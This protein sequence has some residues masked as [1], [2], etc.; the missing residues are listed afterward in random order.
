[1]A[2]HEFPP[3][4]LE[5]LSQGRVRPM[6]WENFAH[7]KSSHIRGAWHVKIYGRFMPSRLKVA[8]DPV[9]KQ[10]VGHCW[11][12][13]LVPLCPLH[14][15]VSQGSFSATLLSQTFLAKSGELSSA[16]GFVESQLCHLSPCGFCPWTCGRTAL[17]LKPLQVFIGPPWVGTGLTTLLARQLC[18]SAVGDAP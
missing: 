13:S 16:L 12:H 9:E 3:Y 8:T 15:C 7:K 11:S 18:P 2:L 4:G 17:P 5:V 14:L 10:I 6:W 1:M